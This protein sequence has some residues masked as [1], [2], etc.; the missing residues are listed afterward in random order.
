MIVTGTSTSRLSELRK[1][2]ITNNFAEMYTA[3]G[4]VS[5]DGVDYSTSTPSN[6]IYYLGGIRYLDIPSGSNSGTTYSFTAQGYNS[7]DF[8]NVPYYKDP[9]KEN[10]ISK[11]KIDDDVFIIRQETSA[12]ENNYRLEY[13]KNLNDLISYAGGNY[14]KIINNS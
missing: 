14:F 13:V 3:N 9:M 10:I 7:P 1:Y 4:S 5:N 8:I 12:F 6:I 11:P 2:R